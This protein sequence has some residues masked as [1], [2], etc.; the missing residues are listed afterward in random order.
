MNNKKLSQ[1]INFFWDEHILPALTEYIKIPNKS[2]V[3]DS[4]WESRG[5]MDR[6]LDLAVKWANKHRS[7]DSE[8][9]IKRTPGRTPIIL[10][11]IPGGQDG[12]ILMYGHL[13]K[14]PEMAGWA[15]GLGPW[16]PVIKDNKLYGRGAADDGYALFASVCA[17]RAL[18]KQGIVHPR[19]LILI[20]FSEE[21]GSPDLP[22]YMELCS[23]LIG[24]PDL[25]ICLDSG[26]G[27][28]DRFW[29]TTSLR[30]LIGFSLRI[31][32][33]NEGVHSGDASGYVPSSF[34]IARQL[35]SRLE[36]ENTGEILLEKLKV[37][38][39]DY[40]IQEVKKLVS[41]LGKNIVDDFPWKGTTM[42]STDNILEAVLRRTWRPALSVV[43]SDGLPA[44]ENAGNVLRPYT[45]LKLSMRIPPMV[46]PL[47]ARDT[48]Q[49]ILTK[50]VPYNAR[51][52]VDFDEPAAGWNAP[53]TRPWLVSAMNNASETFFGQSAGS[54]GTGG[55]IPFMAMLGERFPGAQFVITGVLGPQSNAHGP[56]EFLHIPY[57][58]NLTACVSAVI[59]VFPEN[60]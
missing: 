47:K 56:N 58:K 43:G 27:D 17:V 23:K 37:D 14:Q 42:P 39:P 53:E 46:D 16:T 38:I 28:Y 40:R 6:V 33:L 1:Y 4:D 10:I 52:Q 5:H 15:D 12:N 18:E 41:I 25:V 55:T 60:R 34:R 48:I 50:N 21:S 45:V 44:V 3:F 9:I 54:M 20:E 11:D 7:R 26:A 29:T 49:K 30:G 32:V 19:I 2:P 22:H 8:L 36:N 31:D 35:L 57:A 51:A 59:S 24:E 13:D